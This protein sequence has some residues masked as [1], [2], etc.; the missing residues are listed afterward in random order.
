LPNPVKT[1]RGSVAVTRLNIT[2][3][4]GTAQALLAQPSTGRGPGVLFFMDAMG[5]RAAIEQ[6][7][8]RIA[9]QG[10]TVLAPDVFYRSQPYG[11]FDPK[12]VFGDKDA[13]RALGRMNR[14]FAN[15][16]FEKDSAHYLRALDEN[17][18]GSPAI[19][20]V[21]YCMGGRCALMLGGFHPDRVRAVASFHGGELAVE[22]EQSPHLLADRMK[23]LVYIGVAETDA[24]FEGPE[25]AKLLGA[26]RSAK[27]NHTL[28][29]FPGTQ[30]GFAI[31]DLPVFDQEA[32]ET[33]WERLFDLFARVQ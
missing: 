24:F 9:A 3:P 32:A 1:G 17:S 25:E 12:T 33:H 4:D 18:D 27:V 15:E 8:E 30:H 22:H 7:V 31:S 19:C 13:L 29:T 6:M 21:G 20:T 10:Y 14:A 5:L 26:L 11:P 28:E 16:L 23:G 2:T